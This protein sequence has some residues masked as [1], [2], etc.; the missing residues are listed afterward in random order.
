MT[1]SLGKRIA[2]YGSAVTM[3]AKV[4][5]GVVALSL[6]SP[7]LLMMISPVFPERPSGVTTQRTY[8]RNSA[9]SVDGWVMSVR[10]ISIVVAPGLASTF[11]SPLA[12]DINSVPFRSTFVLPPPT[13][14][15]IALTDLVVRLESGTVCWACPAAMLAAKDT[16][17][18]QK[19]VLFRGIIGFSAKARDEPQTVYRDNPREKAPLSSLTAVET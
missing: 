6:P 5:A 17:I 10:L 15:P 11:A 18:K 4:W 9:P 2:K 8:V 19:K 3:R 16:V 7:F 14:Y 13:L 12:A 1:I